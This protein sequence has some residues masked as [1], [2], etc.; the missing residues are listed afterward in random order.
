MLDLSEPVRLA[1]HASMAV[2]EK[3]RKPLTP[4]AKELRRQPRPVIE[5]AIVSKHAVGE[6]AKAL[7]HELDTPR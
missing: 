3:G 2:P 1:K 5:A 4:L 7:N 6:S